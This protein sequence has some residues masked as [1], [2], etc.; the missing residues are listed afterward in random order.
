MNTEPIDMTP[1]IQAKSDQVNADNLLGAPITVQILGVKVGDGEQP[2][3]I[4]ISGGHMVWRPCK[5]SRRILVA[6]WGADAAKWVGRWVRLFR[7]ET[8]KWAGVEV[9]G[10]RIDAVS[11]IDQPMNLSLAVSKKVKA[12]HKVGVLRPNEQ[13]NAGPATADLDAYLA[14]QKLTRA[15][16]DR[17]RATAGKQPL[18]TLNDSE[19]A[20][21]AAWLA[22]DSKRLDAIRALVPDHAG[23]D[24][25]DREPGD[26]S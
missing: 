7:D 13:K 2:V 5:T 4:K 15:D 23:D 19:R 11:H 26:E 22:A 14:E 24:R 10:I 1:Y 3:S 16:V 21:V 9:G 25:L 12:T 18:D 8:V 17:W 6:V 20:Q